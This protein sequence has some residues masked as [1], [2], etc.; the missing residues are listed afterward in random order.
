MSEVQCKKCP[1][2]TVDLKL[3]VSAPNKTVVGALPNADFLVITWT[4]AETGAMAK[5]LGKGVH[6][7]ETPKETT[8]T[9]LLIHGMAPPAEAEYHAFF[10]Q[11]TVNGKTVVCLKSEFHPKVQTAA[12]TIFFEKIIGAAANQNFKY[13]VTSGTAGGIWASLDI[14]DV[15][16]T[17]SARYGMTM[18]LEKQALR[19]SGVTDLVGGN[20]PAGHANWFEYA[21]SQILKDDACVNTGLLTTGGR[22]ATSPKPAIYYKPTSGNPTDVM[23]NSRISEDECGKIR[24]YRTYG[25]TLD[26]NDAYVAEA[27]KAVG[28]GNWVSIRNV[29][30]LPCSPNT[31]QYDDFG[32]CSSLNGAYAVWAFVMGH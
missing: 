29:S 19:F 7:F 20:P 18:P 14:G 30:D 2:T 5:I 22:H 16:V 10:F 24:T 15:V 11:T 9:P 23:T 31:E 4:A 32:F 6:S 13:A 27:F 21:T 12:T 17:G 25:A 26:E 3:V 8:L 1:A 28:F